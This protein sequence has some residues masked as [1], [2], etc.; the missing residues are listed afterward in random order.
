M[1]G[2]KKVW[3]R[4]PSA[5]EPAWQVELAVARLGQ[6]DDLT[7]GYVVSAVDGRVLFRKD[8]QEHQSFSY[9]VWASDP[10]TLLPDDGPQG[11][12]GTP[13]P[14]GQADG[15]QAPFAPQ[16]LVTLQSLPF[17][18]NDPWLPAG[19]VETT[20]NNVDAYADLTAPDGFT[21]L[22]AD[23]A[24]L[25]LR[26]AATGPTAF[27][28]AYD[29]AQDPQ[30]STTQ[31]QAAVTQLFYDNN[32]LHD[33]FYDAGFDEAAGNAQALNFGR[34]GAEG[35][36]LHVEA[37][38]FG[39]INNANMATPPDGFSPRMQMYLWNNGDLVRTLVNAPAGLAG[40]KRS[41]SAAF[42]QQTFELTG[43]LVPSRPADGCGAFL[44]PSTGP[45]QIA[46][47]DRGTCTF[48]VKVKNAQNAG[49]AGALVRNVLAASPLGT[50]GGADPTITIPSLLLGKADGDAF[51]A[52][53]LAGDTI[54]VT[55][56]RVLG[57]LRDGTIDNLIVAHEWAHY[58]SNRLVQDAAGL[59]TV[60][61]RGMGEGWSD[62]VALLQSVREEDAL[63]AAN[64]G[65]AGVYGAAG[66]VGSGTDTFGDPNQGYYYGIRRT[67]YSTDMSKS[68][69]TFR[70]V[71][72]GV[73][74]PAV[75]P[76]VVSNGLP[77]SEVH[78]AGEV[79]ASALWECYAALL[80][81]TQGA[82][83]R[84]SYAEASLRMRE[85]LVAAFKL[86]PLSPTF[87]E[88][89]DALLA[90][91]F[92]ADRTDFDR[93]WAAF[94]K[95]GFGVG[96]VGPASRFS[97]TNGGVAESFALGG[98]VSLA[99]SSFAGVTSGCDDRDGTLDDGET[100]TLTLRLL[101]TGSGD[102]PAGAGTLTSSSPSLTFPDGGSVTVGPSVVGG[103]AVATVRVSAS[104]ATTA[105][106]AD[107]TLTFADGYL[108][109]PTTLPFQLRLDVDVL[110]AASATDT[111]EGDT[112]AW[113]PSADPTLPTSAAFER[114]TGNAVDHAIFAP[115]PASAADIR[116]TSPPL[117]VGA[118]PFSI[119]WQHFFWFEADPSGTPGQVFY[120]G[121]VVE[122]SDDGGLTW[123]D[124]GGPAYNGVI[125]ATGFGN[126]L[127]GRPGFVEVS[128]S[129]F[130]TGALDPVSL[131]LTSACTGGSA[132]AGKTV[133]FRFRIGADAAF[134][135]LGWYID[136]V[137]V[138]GITNTPFDLLTD[139][140]RR[141]VNRPPSA[142]AGADQ[143]VNEGGP[144]TL[145][146]AGSSDPDTGAVLGYAWTQTAGPAVVLSGAGGVTATFTAP[147]VDAATTLA[148]LVTVSDGVSS[149]SA[150]TLVTVAN[151]NRAPVAAAGPAQSV[152]ERTVV[153]LDG[154]G[155]SDADPGS[156]L[157]YSWAQ[158]GGPGVTLLGGEGPRPS[159]V[160]PEVAADATLTFGLTV[161]DGQ[162]VS[163]TASVVITVRNVNRAP[164]ARAGATQAVDEGATVTLDGAA[165]SDPD[166]GTTLGY[167]WLQT[168]GPAVTLSSASAASPTFAAPQVTTSTLLTFRLTVSDGTD[169]SSAA[170]DVLVRDVNRAP[171]A[172]TS[173]QQGAFER[174]L[175]T[176]DGSSSSDPDAGTVLGFSW[177]QTGGPTVALLGPDSSQPTFA[178]PEV[179]A[180]GATLTFE[181]V[182]SDG[183]VQSAPATLTVLVSNVNR[184]PT[185]NAGA[186]FAAEE[187]SS[188]LVEGAG[189]DDDGA[190][191][192]YAWVQLG[193][194]TVTL[195]GA[196]TGAVTFTAPEV[197]ASTEVVLELT[198]SDGEDS[199]TSEVAV[200]ITNVNRP[201]VAQAGPA[202]VVN[203][204]VAVSLDAGASADPD[205]GAALT[206]AWTQ[207]AGPA[208]AL[209]GAATAAPSFTAPAGPAT[210]T[211]QVTVGDGAALS[212][213]SV[214]VTVNAG[215]DSGGGGCGC[216]AGG[217]NP[218]A[219]VPFLFGLA[220]LRRRRVRP[221]AR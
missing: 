184:P 186:P 178:A 138:G 69:L 94:A 212:T 3:F 168:A 161:S 20:G 148:F 104:G 85:Y 131:D 28:Y 31:I 110:K 47:V 117:R 78:N 43:D 97:T 35:D 99:G 111:L 65:W 106:L 116:L 56:Q 220:F 109:Q 194:P 171:V 157:T 150:T 197:A 219:L 188:V 81:D 7:Y 125:T 5:L 182:V 167:T 38:D 126:P 200:T 100:G 74:L 26:A 79:W 205:A 151:V 195:A 166:A 201:P 101:N 199:A 60:Q 156:V 193:G 90:V 83:P 169:S 39:G 130:V 16:G 68:P 67:P 145:S 124:V 82:T 159:F 165:S 198:V 153:T 160:A 213:A 1:A 50:M 72:D 22:A 196:D 9:R 112:F 11:L 123:R 13:H 86:L 135:E 89:R 218:A 64:A 32:A 207:T 88:G 59:D 4:F 163:A 217:G 25:D 216:S 40:F 202:Q 107:L 66:F 36:P 57:R 173:G 114:L 102:L 172:S 174:D 208:V 119:S 33:W 189:A 191:L 17:S 30:A 176:L 6:A 147:A 18:Q 204:G 96:A 77:N 177:T 55:L 129:L 134:G 108:A 115:N 19:A 122:L 183:R 51:G 206:Y 144:V 113:T 127:E 10:A 91:A 21:S 37:Q 12:A 149:S 211:F 45:G 49:Y 152:A 46:L 132:C 41:A 192:T 73:P 203:P 221:A 15:Y 170:V 179:D 141:C 87:L 103:E 42:G 27:D 121:G 76:P 133:L 162:A 58:L 105:E 61:A 140:A 44:N 62:F 158:T 128:P 120:D 137:V 92:A 24:S 93:L 146:A 63:S 139:D 34:G 75:T 2:A 80:R 98:E 181:L 214:T 54:N 190:A 136:D 175:V 52:A 53:I 14:T 210:L 215:S 143:L 187:R 209:S 185:A 70:H 180:A 84:L 48:T 155:S 29:L 118:G 71:A 164:T 8:Q 154:S 23:P 142:A 95:R